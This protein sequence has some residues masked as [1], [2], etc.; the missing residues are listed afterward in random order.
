MSDATDES[1]IAEAEAAIAA[2][3]APA[4]QEKPEP[5]AEAP[6][7]P[8]PKSQIEATASKIGWAG[9]DEW[10]GDPADWIDAP[11]FILK[12]AGEVLPSMRKSLEDARDEIKGLKKAVNASIKH[13]SKARQ[14]GYEQRSR[15][16]QA[17]LAQYAEAGDVENVKSVTKDIVALE[18][19]VREEV[20]DLPEEPSEFT[21]WREANPWYG[22]DEAHSAAC[23]AIGKK[24]F[25]EGYTGKAQIAE[26]DRRMREKFPGLFAKPENPNRRLP[27]AVEGSGTVIRRQGGKSFSDMPREHQDMCLDLMKQSKT[28]TKENYAKEY[29]AEEKR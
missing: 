29:F 24:V 10:K 23:D 5:K 7:E 26:V 27:G 8:A 20:A 1:L 6:A 17:E 3:E 19:E 2:E 11:D 4:A 25:E 13:I 18:K 21:A 22:T 28:I 9:K 16:L 14:D 15:E 12:A